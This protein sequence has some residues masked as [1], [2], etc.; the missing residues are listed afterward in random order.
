MK[1]DNTEHRFRDLSCKGGPFGASC[2]CPVAGCKFYAALRNSE[3]R[4]PLRPGF[5]LYAHL[6]GLVWA[7]MKDAH[8]DRGA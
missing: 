7:H 3:L 1:I 6:R 4:Y 2:A 5:A 8:E